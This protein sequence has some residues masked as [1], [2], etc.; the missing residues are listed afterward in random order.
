M[1]PRGWTFTGGAIAVSG[2]LGALLLVL[3]LHLDARAAGLEKRYDQARTDYELLVKLRLKYRELEA[4]QLRM[5]PD[6]GTPVSWP[7]FLAQKAQ[8]AGLP[9]PTIVPETPSRG[10]L[11]ESAFTVTLGGAASSAI[12]RRAFV[13]FL[14]LVES[15]RPG[16]KSK[17]IQFKFSSAA[18]DDFQS[19][20]A[21]FSHFER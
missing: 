18:P 16:F 11:K 14:D 12:P 8:E 7:T 1:K 2:A 3:I 5:P 9:T 15:Q 21:T 17:N 10:A 4:R 6:Q 13:K 19:A 20:S